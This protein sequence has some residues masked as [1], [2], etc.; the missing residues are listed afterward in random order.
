MFAIDRV[1]T[2]VSDYKSLDHGHTKERRDCLDALI[3]VGLV[4]G[5]AV[6]R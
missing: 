3:H 4:D 5:E 2:S 6:P 1:V